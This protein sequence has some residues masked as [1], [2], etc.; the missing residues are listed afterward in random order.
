MSVLPVN[1]KTQLC[2]CDMLDIVE[3]GRK[4]F[5]AYVCRS[6]LQMEPL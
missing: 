5:E 1:N 6:E 3:V 4:S 2:E